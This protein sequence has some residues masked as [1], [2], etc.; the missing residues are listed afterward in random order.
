MDVRWVRPPRVH[1]DP[2]EPLVAVSVFP[3]AVE[4]VFDVAVEEVA[5]ELVE[6]VFDVAVE[7]VADVPVEAFFLH[8]SL[9]AAEALLALP[10]SHSSPGSSLPL[11]QS[12]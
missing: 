1:P 3:S 7:E 10:S 11:P 9:Q 6:V 5:E 8:V 2:L 12:P 4:V